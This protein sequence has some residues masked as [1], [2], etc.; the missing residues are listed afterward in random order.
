MLMEITNKGK[1]R[2]RLLKHLYINPGQTLEVGDDIGA[3]AMRK[4]ADIEGKITKPKYTPKYTP[5]KKP[6]IIE[7]DDVDGIE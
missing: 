5:K 1:R 2:I 7:E 3:Y 6:K 4:H